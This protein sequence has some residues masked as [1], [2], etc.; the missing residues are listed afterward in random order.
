MRRTKKIK[1]AIRIIIRNKEIYRF[2]VNETESFSMILG[3]LMLRLSAVITKE[4]ADVHE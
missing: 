1:R 4:V 2:G 3:L